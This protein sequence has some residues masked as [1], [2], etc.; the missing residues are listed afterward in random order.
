MRLSARQVTVVMNFVI[1]P[2]MLGLIA[3][4]GDFIAVCLPQRWLPVVPY[5]RILCL[6]GLFAP[7]SVVS[8]NIL[9]I[10]S[11]GRLIFRLEIV[12]KAI[13]TLIL[14]LTIPI[15]VRAIAWGQTIIYLSDAIINMLGAG[16][17]LH[18]TLRDGIRTTLPYLA[19]SAIMVGAVY[20]THLLLVGHT[21]LWAVLAV[22]IAA[23]IAV[24][25]LLTLLFRP[26]GWREVRT[27]LRQA[28]ASR[29]R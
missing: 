2:V 21:A 28:A 18:W 11:D 25:A 1:F 12:K 19:M 15:S 16:R 17:Y 9:K 23:G 24:Y 3:V 14:I 29:N 10:K 13:A 4:V 22:E 20:G 26:E 27:V 6:S 8:Y 7:L 5:F